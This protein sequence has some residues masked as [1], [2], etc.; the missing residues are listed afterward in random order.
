MDRVLNQFNLCKGGD[1]L[2]V[3]GIPLKALSMYLFRIFFGLV[4]FPNLRLVTRVS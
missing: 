3:N 4:L 1:H 2:L